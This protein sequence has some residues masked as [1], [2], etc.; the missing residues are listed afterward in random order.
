MGVRQ[1][2]SLSTTLFSL[3]LN[4]MAIGIKM[5][6]C[7]VKVDMVDVSILMH[8]DDV[9]LLSDTEANLQTMLNYVSE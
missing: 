9:V 2:G 6:E 5:L 3:Y 1:G 7:G 4:D 8:A